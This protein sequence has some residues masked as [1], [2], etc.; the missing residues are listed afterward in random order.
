MIFSWVTAFIC[1]IVGGQEENKKEKFNVFTF[2]TYILKW[3]YFPHKHVH[4]VKRITKTCTWS[5]SKYWYVKFVYLKSNAQ[6]SISTFKDFKCKYIYFVTST[7]DWNYGIKFE[8]VNTTYSIQI[9]V[10]SFWPRGFHLHCLH[11]DVD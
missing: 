4:K 2:C 7:S 3:H 1:K 5:G 11:G 8:N 9:K 6:S 10:F